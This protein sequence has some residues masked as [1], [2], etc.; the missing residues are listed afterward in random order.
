MGHCPISPHGNK[1]NKNSWHFFL[2]VCYQVILF[3]EVWTL[4]KLP[5][6]MV[7]G[8]VDLCSTIDI[9][10]DTINNGKVF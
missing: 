8:I 4:T 10:H 5:I 6:H 9:L 2:P 3:S 1:N 7:L